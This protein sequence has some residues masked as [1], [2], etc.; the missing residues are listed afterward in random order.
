MNDAGLMCLEEQLDRRAELTGLL[1][2]LN[3]NQAY[4]LR[5]AE[6]IR[7]GRPDNTKNRV[8]SGRYRYARVVHVHSGPRSALPSREDFESG[9]RLAGFSSPRRT[10]IFRPHFNT[11]AIGSIFCLFFFIIPNSYIYSYPPS[12]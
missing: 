1:K 4:V 6:I 11:I 12:P 7:H 8:N 3:G 2:R 10:E 9:R 5:T